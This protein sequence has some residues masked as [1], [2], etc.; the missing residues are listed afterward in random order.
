MTC[1]DWGWRL[2]RDFL[3]ASLKPLGNSVKTRPLQQ[4]IKSIEPELYALIH[5][6]DVTILRTRSHKSQNL[7]RGT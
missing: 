1:A 3:V 7:V 2:G 6:D 4:S 5:T